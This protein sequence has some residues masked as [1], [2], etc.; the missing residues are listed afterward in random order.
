MLARP[1]GGESDKVGFWRSTKL[2]SA[3]QT[4]S[5]N[6]HILYVV[7]YHLDKIALFFFFW[8]H[9]ILIPSYIHRIPGLPTLGSISCWLGLLLNFCLPNQSLS[10][11]CL[12]P[13]DF[14]P[15]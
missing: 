13:S 10:S 5:V 11:L 8:T 12:I 4:L 9:T 7:T 2:L 14:V 15:K 3:C 1:R 6:I